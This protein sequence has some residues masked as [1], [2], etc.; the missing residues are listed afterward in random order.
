MHC[1]FFL[2]LENCLVNGKLYEKKNILNVDHSVHAPTTKI[3]QDKIMQKKNQKQLIP[4]N[5]CVFNPELEHV[6]DDEPS[7]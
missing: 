2:P 5:I 7:Y 1:G 6:I 3:R 4:H